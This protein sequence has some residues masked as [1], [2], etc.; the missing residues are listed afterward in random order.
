MSTVSLHDTRRFA[1]ERT[2]IRIGRA[3]VVWGERREQIDADRSDLYR[4]QANV[5][6]Q[7]ALRAAAARSQLL[8]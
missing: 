1:I 6:D 4:R 5:R 7:Q 3:L 2:V 8:P